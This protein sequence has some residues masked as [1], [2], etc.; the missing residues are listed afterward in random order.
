MPKDKLMELRELN[1]KIKLGGG[2]KAIDKQ[3]ESGKL[4]ARERILKLLDEGS[5]SEIDAFVEHRCVNFGMDKKK[6]PGE[7]V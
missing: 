7:G 2:Q 3:H 5:F 4:T 1:E 6:Y